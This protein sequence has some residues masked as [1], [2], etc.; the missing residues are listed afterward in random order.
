MDVLLGINGGILLYTVSMISYWQINSES[1][2]DKRLALVYNS[3]Y[4]THKFPRNK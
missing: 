4:Y 2:L 3:P 1:I